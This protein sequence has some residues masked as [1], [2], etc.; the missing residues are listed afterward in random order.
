MFLN[1]FF[2]RIK[3]SKYFLHKT[4]K[5]VLLKFILIV[6]ILLAYFVFV[7]FKFGV[8]EWL[9]VTVLTWSFFVFCTPIAD[10]GFLLDFPIRLITKMKMLYSEILIWLIAI[11]LNLLMLNLNSDVYSSTHL[12]QLFK[13][14]LSNPIPF[15]AIILVSGLW[16]FLSI[17]FGDELIDVVKHKHRL[18]YKKHKSK[19]FLIIFVFVILFVILLYYYLLKKFGISLV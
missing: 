3:K 8:W 10:A 14:I 4:K 2:V 6:I 16:T 11:V 9:G 1:N 18:K 13:H 12:L 15:W 5:H 17:Y 19:Y 7:S